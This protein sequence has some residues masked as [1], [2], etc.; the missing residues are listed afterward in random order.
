MILW[1]NRGTQSIRANI[2][3]VRTPWLEAILFG[4]ILA[5]V[6]TI[7]IM[8]RGA[9][10]AASG[11]ATSAQTSDP[12]VALQ[13]YEGMVTDSRCGAKHE[14]A[15]ARSAT[16]CVRA[17]VHAGE[18]FALVQG[19]NTYILDGDLVVIKN[20]AGQRARIIGTLSGDTI[21]VSSIT[22]AD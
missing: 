3:K 1:S 10:A 8:S 17:C 14:P 12:S 21:T 13:S 16:D 20:L 5:C 11:G 9:Q 18:K 2:I 15:I 6:F 7:L 19:N 4:A 22:A